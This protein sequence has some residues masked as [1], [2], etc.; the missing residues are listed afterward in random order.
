M[1]IELLV[2][3]LVGVMALVGVASGGDDNDEGNAAEPPVEEHDDPRSSL[4]GTDNADELL[5][6]DLIGDISGEDGDDL[7]VSFGADGVL[8]GGDGDDAIILTSG[9]GTLVGGSG[10]DI[11]V[12]LGDE[13]SEADT[14]AVIKDF[15]IEEDTLVLTYQQSSI[16]D[17]D[18]AGSSGNI[19]ITSEE[20]ETETG[21]ALKLTFE[22]RAGFEDVT[23][24]IGF[25]SVTLEGVTESELEGVNFLAG[26]DQ[27]N[28]EDETLDLVDALDT[29]VRHYDIFQIGTA[30]DGDISQM[31]PQNGTRAIFGLAGDDRL[32]SEEF[33]TTDLYGGDGDDMLVQT[34][35]LGHAYGGDGND[36]FDTQVGATLTGGNGDDVF[37]VFRDDAPAEP[38]TITDFIL[39]EDTL[40]LNASFSDFEIVEGQP[41][42]NTVSLQNV[43]RDGVDGTLVTTMHTNSVGQSVD[44]PSVFLV[45]I[46]SDDIPEGTFTFDPK[47]F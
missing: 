47:F 11:F 9:D 10:E 42:T 18:V 3:M 45:G 43:T 30:E 13:E 21:T 15:D 19:Q 33:V 40:E 41:G 34:F 37:R 26:L 16:A 27:S 17:G 14:N 35:S 8:D 12:V 20:I 4:E 44:G 23:E 32:V 1:G 25:S 7:I 24:S 6:D 22:S 29:G 38:T 5:G 2:A 39:G 31:T 28:S 46:A 36:T